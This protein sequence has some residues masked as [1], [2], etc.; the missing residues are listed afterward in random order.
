MAKIVSDLNQSKSGTVYKNTPEQPPS[1]ATSNNC[2]SHGMELNVNVQH[3][4][5]TINAI[6]ALSLNTF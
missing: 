6:G 5:K 3:V 4:N 1:S 2:Y